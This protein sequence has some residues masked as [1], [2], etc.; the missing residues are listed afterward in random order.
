MVASPW[1][2]GDQ[3]S[4]SQSKSSADSLTAHL[5]SESTTPAC[6]CLYTLYMA[7]RQPTQE[8]VKLLKDK[9]WYCKKKHMRRFNYSL[10]TASSHIAFTLTFAILPFRSTISFSTFSRSSPTPSPSHSYTL[11]MNL[12][13]CTSHAPL[14]LLSSSNILSAFSTCCAEATLSCDSNDAR[15]AASSMQNPAPAP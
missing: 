8:I 2:G 11:P 15:T 10:A 6:A 4:P 1:P 9:V 3:R 7:L 5:H 14:S 12:L 13:L